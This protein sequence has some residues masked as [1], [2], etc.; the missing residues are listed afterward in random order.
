MGAKI[1]YCKSCNKRE[2][3]LRVKVQWEKGSIAKL[4]KLE[5]AF[6]L[7]NFKLGMNATKIKMCRTCF[8]MLKMG[9]GQFLFQAREL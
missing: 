1:I 5:R 3:E 7:R 8:D 4:N 2:I 9:S 6:I